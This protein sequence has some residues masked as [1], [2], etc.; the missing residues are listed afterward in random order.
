MV[1]VIVLAGVTLPI[2]S[3][4]SNGGATLGTFAYQAEKSGY[5]ENMTN[6]ANRMKWPNDERNDES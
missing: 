3:V 2:L 6:D 1:A 5:E 4:D